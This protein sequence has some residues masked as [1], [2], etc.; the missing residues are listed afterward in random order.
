MKHH[1]GCRQSTWRA[2]DRLEKQ[3]GEAARHLAE[4]QHKARW[5]VIDAVHA[6]RHAAEEHIVNGADPK[7]RLTAALGPPRC[8]CGDALARRVDARTCG[9]S[10]CRTKRFRAVPFRRRET[11]WVNMTTAE[12]RARRADRLLTMMLADRWTA[13]SRDDVR[14]LG[15]GF[16]LPELEADR[17]VEELVDDGAMFVQFGSADVVQ[18]VPPQ[19]RLRKK[20]RQWAWASGVASSGQPRLVRAPP[21]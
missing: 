14:L 9:Q 5:S 12:K 11:R 21:C 18:F 13:F 1:R 15:R 6:A 17:L 10:R 20:G 4:K 16:S 19:F 7:A 8:T 3:Y 2:F